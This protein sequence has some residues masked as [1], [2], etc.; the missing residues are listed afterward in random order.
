M[1]HLQ[2]FLKGFLHLI[3]AILA[4][5]L[6]LLFF[7]LGLGYALLTFRV[8]KSKYLFNL[9]FARDKLGNAELGV[10]TNDILKKKGGVSF[11]NYDQ[12]ISYSIGRNKQLNTLTMLGRGVAN[13]LDFFDK[14]HCIK[15][16]E[17]YNKRNGIF[18]PLKDNELDQEENR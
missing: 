7:P 3:L 9:A 5:G 12:T 17:T 13:V 8:S 2:I 14:D 11:G 6:G 1:K 10:I 4:Y 16:V 18:V 15:A